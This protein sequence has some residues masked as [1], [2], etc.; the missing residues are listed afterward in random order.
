MRALLAAGVLLAWAGASAAAAVHLQ[1]D[2]ADTPLNPATAFSVYR[3]VGCTGD[4]LFLASTPRPQQAYADSTVVPGQLYCYYVTATSATGE[5]SDASNVAQF[6]V[7][8]P[9]PPA[10]TNLRGVAAR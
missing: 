8:L 6:L 3:D 10:P 7:P 5:E 9:R 1:W 4:F 2:Y